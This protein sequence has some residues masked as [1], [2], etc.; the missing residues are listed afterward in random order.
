MKQPLYK[1][2]LSDM[3]TKEKLVWPSE[4][5]KV[6]LFSKFDFRK[7]DNFIQPYK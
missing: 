4:S 1:P 2:G 3:H 6:E 5:L 7:D